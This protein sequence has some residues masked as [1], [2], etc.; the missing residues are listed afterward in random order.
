MEMRY[1][2]ARGRHLLVT[3]VAPAG[4][5]VCYLAAAV[6]AQTAAGIANAKVPPQGTAE[7]SRGARPASTRKVQANML[8]LMRGILYP[9][10]NVIFAAQADIIKLAP[11]A[12]PSVSPNPLTSTYGGWQAVENAGLALAEAANLVVLPGRL[13]S[14]GRPAPVQRADWVKYTQGLRDAGLAA[15]KAAQSKSEDAMVEVSGRVADACS[16]CHD[17]YREKKGGVADRCLP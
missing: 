16:S 4:V 10:S 6:G 8:Q 3:C 2:V 12:D 17:V 11:V 14:N 7:P 5:I 15:Y 13:C 1:V 9:S